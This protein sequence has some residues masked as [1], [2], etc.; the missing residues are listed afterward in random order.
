MTELRKDL[1][2]EGTRI[3]RIRILPPDLTETEKLYKYVFA[4]HSKGQAVCGEITC[5]IC[6]WEK[7][8]PKP[9]KPDIIPFIHRLMQ[10]VRRFLDEENS[11]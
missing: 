8:H 1:W 3:G 7:K 11:R 2:L 6:E 5:R 9:D 4:A 10:V